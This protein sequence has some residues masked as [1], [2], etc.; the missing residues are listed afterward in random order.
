MK[1]T[2]LPTDPPGKIQLNRL[3]HALR[4]LT[5]EHQCTT[6]LSG[7]IGVNESSCSFYSPFGVAFRTDVSEVWERIG[8]QY[9]WTASRSNAAAVVA[10]IQAA[11]PALR[12]ARPVVDNRVTPEQDT[13]RRA[14]SKQQETDLQEAQH[15]EEE[16]WAALFGKPGAAG[17]MPNGSQMVVSLR[18]CFD[19]SDC[20]SDYFCSHAWLSPA[21]AL[22]IVPKQHETQALA[23]HGLALLP[24]LADLE[25]TWHTE[26]YSMGHGNY[27]ESEAFVFSPE[28]AALIGKRE[29]YDGSGPVNSGHWEIQFTGNKELLPHRAFQESACPASAADSSATQVCE[30]EEHDGVEIRFPSKPAGEI[31]TQLKANGW[32]WSRHAGCWYKHRSETALAFARQLTAQA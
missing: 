17:V 23:R 19:D 14:E 11:L 3:N 20:R 22:L 4:E 13:A 12:A 32:R 6:D 5:S 16:R 15:V 27:L 25:W 31:L 2:A 7:V 30:N 26:N 24:E 29:H 9:E 28:V 10:D 1:W 21:F 8:S 18:L